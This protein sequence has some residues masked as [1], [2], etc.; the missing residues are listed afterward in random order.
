MVLCIASY[1]SARINT[2]G[3]QGLSGLGSHSGVENDRRGGCRKVD[4]GDVLQ[5]HIEVLAVCRIAGPWA[6]GCGTRTRSRK[7]ACF[8]AAPPNLYREA[9]I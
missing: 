6:L 1:G 3:P 8:V 4:C 9:S 5:D 7:F 2:P